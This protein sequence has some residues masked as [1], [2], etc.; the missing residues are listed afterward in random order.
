MHMRSGFFVIAASLWSGTVLA[1][2]ICGNIRLSVSEQIECRGRI[3]N[4][5]GEGD[6]TRIQQEFDDRVRR[7]NDQ[8][9]TP[10]VMR[11][12]APPANSPLTSIAKP[13]LPPPPT[14]PE[15]P[16]LPGTTA[17]LAPLPSSPSGNI[18]RGAAGPGYDGAGAGRVSTAAAPLARI[19]CEDAAGSTKYSALLKREQIASRDS[20]NRTSHTE[21]L[22]TLGRWPA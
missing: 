22:N 3:T 8:L 4:S 19:W 2:D 16:L 1:Q 5:L 7:A 12:P 14:A 20:K 21:H 15:A 18:A 13:A 10:P 11:S 6:R 9:I 17:P